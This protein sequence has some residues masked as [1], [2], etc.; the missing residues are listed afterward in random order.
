MDN[1]RPKQILDHTFKHLEKV[2]EEMKQERSRKEKII[3]SSRQQNERKP[4]DE[5]DLS[6]N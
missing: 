4:K 5:A 2:L 1:K 3:K 6:F